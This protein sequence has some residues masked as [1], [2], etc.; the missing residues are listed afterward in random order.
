MNEPQSHEKLERGY[1][2]P[3]AAILSV[4]ASITCCLPLAFLAA[5]GAAGASAVFAVLRPW[6]L[7]I[8]AAMLAIGFLQLY[9]KQKC[10]RRSPAAV[11]LL[12]IAVAI[13]LAMLFFPQQVAGLFAGHLLL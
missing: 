13:F 9:R 4:I 12:W 5:L 1:A 7:V 6:L 8:S 3:I 11:A 10:S 2:A